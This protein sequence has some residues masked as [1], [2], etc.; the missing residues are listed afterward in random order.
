MKKIFLLALLVP[1]SLNATNKNNRYNI[2]AGTNSISVAGNRFPLNTLVLKIYPDSINVQIFTLNMYNGYNYAPVTPMDSFK[3]Y[4][5]AGTA[6]TSVSQMDSF[7]QAK[8]VK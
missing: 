7:Y 6:F 4:T 3:H 2:V 1:L 8:F 5:N